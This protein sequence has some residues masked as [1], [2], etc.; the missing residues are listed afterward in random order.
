V[1]PVQFFQQDRVRD[2]SERKLRAYL[3]DV[4]TLAVPVGVE[5]A[6]C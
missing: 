6:T 5:P 4:Q 1:R 3:D 2:V